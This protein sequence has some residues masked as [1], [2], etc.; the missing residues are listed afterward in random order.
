MI[1]T[2]KFLAEKKPELIWA[3]IGDELSYL[4]KGSRIHNTDINDVECVTYIYDHT[5]FAKWLLENQRDNIILDSNTNTIGIG[6]S[7]FFPEIHKRIVE[8]AHRRMHLHMET[9][10]LNFGIEVYVSHLRCQI[11]WEENNME[12]I[13]FASKGIYEDAKINHSLLWSLIGFETNRTLK[14]VSI[15]Q[16]SVKRKTPDHMLCVYNSYSF[17]KWLESNTSLQTI[18]DTICIKVSDLLPKKYNRMSHE[19][20]VEI[21][22]QIRKLLLKYDIECKEI[23]AVPEWQL[24]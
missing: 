11:N 6:T 1:K 14:Q 12:M 23:L 2:A 16:S 24:S 9:V 5:K 7:A 15:Y 21:L 22:L 17:T 8:R 20:Q 4:K 10:L 13:K 19:N 18:D 3:A